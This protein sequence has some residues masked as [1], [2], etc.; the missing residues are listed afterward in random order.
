MRIFDTLVLYITLIVKTNIMHIVGFNEN[1][2]IQYTNRFNKH[3][4]THFPFNNE[5]IQILNLIIFT[6]YVILDPLLFIIL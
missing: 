1:Y 5:F 6:I 3:E 2:I 4:P